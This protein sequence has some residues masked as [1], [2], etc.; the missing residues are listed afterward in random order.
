M[1]GAAAGDKTLEQSRLFARDFF[2]KAVLE[3]TPEEA[4]AIRHFVQLLDETHGETYPRL[5]RRPWKFI[6]TRL[7]L[8]GGFSFTR[9]D[10]IV[11]S[12]RTI[13]RFVR[14]A[15]K[16]PTSTG[17]PSLLLHEQLHV[18]QR[19]K[20]ELFLPLYENVFGFKKTNVTIH[21]WIDERQVSNPDGADENWLVSIKEAGEK[22]PKMYWMGTILVGDK[23]IPTMGRDF[24]GIA[25]EVQ[26][27]NTGFEMVVD[28]DGLPRYRE[29]NEL[30]ELTDR[31]PIRGGYD[32]PN[33][34]A[35]YLLPNIVNGKHKESVRN[36]NAEKVMQLSKK[37]F[38]ENL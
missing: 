38:H 17:P 1:T 27:S 21:P 20:P 32:H 18:L 37:W 3:F 29:L 25:V 11:F 26:M 15:E 22:A 24:S 35:A 12:E 31:F 14:T 36:A 13:T 10:S 16:D 4:A 6:K 2:G 5:I 19:E 9:G 8:C 23:P 34:V 7:D 28:Q 30:P 33:E